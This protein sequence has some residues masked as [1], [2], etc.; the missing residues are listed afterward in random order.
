[1]MKLDF[2][3]KCLRLRKNGINSFDPFAKRNIQIVEKNGE[4]Y[5]C[6]FEVPSTFKNNLKRLFFTIYTFIGIGGIAVW[7][8]IC[9]LITFVWGVGQ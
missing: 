1:M 9:L 8:A 5:A 7:V 6:W 3:F 2:T 4:L